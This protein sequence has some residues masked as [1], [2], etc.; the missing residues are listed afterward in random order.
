[1]TAKLAP[2]FVILLVC[3][4]VGAQERHRLAP[5]LH[6]AI[7]GGMDLVLRQEYAAAESTF[8]DLS[9]RFPRHPAGY[10]YEAAVLQA[11]ALDFGTGVPRPAFDSLLER[12]RNAC[13]ALP[14]PAWAKFFLA[15][16]DGYDAVARAERGDWL[17]G[18]RKGLASASAFEALVAADSGFID[19]YAGVGTYLYWRSRKTA[20]LRWLPFVSD[21]REQGIT[22]LAR[23]AREG[24]Y[25]RFAAVSSLVSLFLDREAYREAETWSRIGL[26]TYPDNRVFLWGLATALDRQHRPAEAVGIYET[27]R[28]S[29]C[30]SH[31][32]NPYNEIV[33]RLNLARCA[34]ASGQ[35]AL[36]RPELSAL[37]QYEHAAFTDDYRSRA[38]EKFDEARRLLES[39]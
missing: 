31:S 24:T 22:L 39:L 19:A 18:I 7:L 8:A 29:I 16:A 9:R 20:F 35:R 13:E 12:G 26:Q 30:S 36:A 27:L 15:T 4:T 34:I 10:L 23:C 21:D 11:Q 38:Q 37:L 1:M 14:D 28:T 2:L 6:E 5:P 32:P 33:C 17:G 3:A 25:N